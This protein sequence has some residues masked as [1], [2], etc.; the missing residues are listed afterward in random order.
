MSVSQPYARWVVW[1]SAV[2]VPLIFYRGVRDSFDV[3]KFLVVTIVGL[4]L[5]PV[6]V[7]ELVS[8]FRP[9]PRTFSGIAASFFIGAVV[10]T[11]VFS[12]RPWASLWGQYQRYTGL[13][14]I[15]SCTALA[16]VIARTFRR[17]D[18]VVLMVVVVSTQAVINLYAWIQ[19]VGADPWEWSSSSFGRFVMS[20][21]GNPNTASA[22][23]VVTLPLAVGCLSK[24]A[25][26][27]SVSVLGAL[28]FSSSV[29]F[30]PVYNSFQGNVGLAASVIALI[31]L[32]RQHRYSLASYCLAASTLVCLVVLMATP[33]SKASLVTV[34]I[35]LA[36]SATILS[37]IVSSRPTFRR[38]FPIHW[39]VVAPVLVGVLGLSAAL[40]WDSFV[41]GVQ[42]GL[43]ERKYF[44]SAAWSAFRDHPVFGSGL[45]T[46]GYLYPQYRPEEHAVSLEASI[47]SS[48]HSIPLGFFV[49]GGVFL[50]VSFVLL[51]GALLHRAFGRLR[52]S[53]EHDDELAPWFAASFLAA[54][55]V[56][57]VSVESIH[58]YFLF[59]MI[60]GGVAWRPSAPTTA[61]KAGSRNRKG[62]SAGSHRF[63]V[64][65]AS[66]VLVVGCL[67]FASRYFRADRSFLEASKVLADPRRQV[68]GLPLLERAV[69]LAPWESSYRSQYAEALFFLGDKQL[70]A[71]EAIRAVSD[72]NYVGLLA[73]QMARIILSNNDFDTGLSILE[74]AISRDPF[75]PQLR[76]AAVDLY[77]QVADYEAQ[78]GLADAAAR[79]RARADELTALAG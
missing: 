27:R 53:V 69:E 29:F 7:S 77:L 47:T 22:F 31:W 67:P 30:I 17:S 59:A 36:S 11:S 74:E 51:V 21:L 38:C 20:T 58:L 48:V 62:R 18:L 64:A 55:S 15:I 33:E 1:S 49:S 42:D 8:R 37:K 28:V 43:S 63:I 26:S 45:E 2:V 54:A 68:E 9:L 10:L 16:V 76:A 70:A 12:S 4:L 71:R 19:F 24:F 56:S 75:A 79:H 6:A 3:T 61:T 73:P 78:Q 41:S 72:A 13:M 57:V 14:T 65:G 50:G 23:T 66:V 44:Y 34:M 35:M 5:L 25:T 60:L 40:L 39:K 46:F 52:S 32:I